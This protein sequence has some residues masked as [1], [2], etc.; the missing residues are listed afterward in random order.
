MHC[1][2]IAE[3]MPL[4]SSVFSPF[5]QC[6]CA[7]HSKAVVIGSCCCS[8]F[9]ALSALPMAFFKGRGRLVWS[10]RSGQPLPFGAGSW[11]ENH[12]ERHKVSMR[13]HPGASPASQRRTASARTRSIALRSAIFARTSARWP[14][15]SSLTSAQALLAVL[16]RKGQQRANFIEGEPEFAGT[17]DKGKCPRFGRAVDPPPAGGARRR[18]EHL[19]ALVIADGLD[20]HPTPSGQFADRQGRW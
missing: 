11:C 8:L 10:R 14:V 3:W 13:G 12:A 1:G 9:R 15:A 7:T 5:Q 18:G 2:K 6:W 4:R 20:I 16:G 17:A 19:D